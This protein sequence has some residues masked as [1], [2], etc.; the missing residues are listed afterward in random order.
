LWKLLSCHLI[1]YLYVNKE[2]ILLC[3]LLQELLL[4]REKNFDWR[5]SYITLY[6]I[7]YWFDNGKYNKILPNRGRWRSL[8][9]YWIVRSLGWWLWRIS[10]YWILCRLRKWLVNTKNELCYL[11]QRIFNKCINILNSRRKLIFIGKSKIV[12][13]SLKIK[14]Y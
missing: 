11:L 2:Y 7:F 4:F 10:N 13:K 3:L 12:K 14:S 9:L 6:R 8:R 1:C 5:N